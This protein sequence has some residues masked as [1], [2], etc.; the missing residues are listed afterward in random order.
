MPPKTK[1]RNLVHSSYD[2]L[3]SKFYES[4]HALSMVSVQ[5]LQEMVNKVEAEAQSIGRIPEGLK[6]AIDDLHYVLRRM[7]ELDADGSFRGNYDLSVFGDAVKLRFEHF[8]SILDE[9]DAGER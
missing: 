3:I 8:L 1:L 9:M 6:Y 2:Y 7:L 5:S 4:E